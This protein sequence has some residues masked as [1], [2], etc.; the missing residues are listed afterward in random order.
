MRVIQNISIVRPVIIGNDKIEEGNI[1]SVVDEYINE[2]T[3]ISDTNNVDCFV[4]DGNHDGPLSQSREHLKI[5]LS[6]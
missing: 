1:I 2:Q 5:Q 3:N 6:G 4:M